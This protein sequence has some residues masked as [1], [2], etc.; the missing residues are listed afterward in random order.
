MLN[1]MKVNLGEN[2]AFNVAANSAICG[3]E[4]NASS[5]KNACVIAEAI[6]LSGV[7]DFAHS[8]TFG[9]NCF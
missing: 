4:R 9:R 2:W 3:E 8:E 5:L 7:I 1:F 6:L